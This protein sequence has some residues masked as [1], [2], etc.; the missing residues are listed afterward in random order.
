MFD[1]ERAPVLVSD[2]ERELVVPIAA[3]TEVI[4]EL[5]MDIYG[6]I[7]IT[8]MGDDEQRRVQI[9]HRINRGVVNLL[10]HRQHGL[11]RPKGIL[12]GARTWSSWWWF[13]FMG[14]E[15]DVQITRRG[16]GGE[17]GGLLHDWVDSCL[18]PH[19]FVGPVGSL[20]TSRLHY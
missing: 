1:Q 11:P 14:E 18:S 9:I 16:R 4:S 5:I 8:M 2:Q 19:V 6:I 10:H 3:D 17:S 7:N 12:G 20:P 13:P 15:D